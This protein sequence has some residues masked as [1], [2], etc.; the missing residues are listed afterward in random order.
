MDNKK[1]ILLSIGFAI[2]AV[3]VTKMYIN[4]R[5]DEYKIKK[6]VKVVVARAR[7]P[8]GTPIGKKSVKA[9]SIPAQ[10]KPKAAVL[11]KDLDIFL[12]Q[13]TNSDIPSGDYVLENTFGARQTVA[14]R[15]SGLVKGDGN[16]RAVNLPVD[17]TNS[18]ANSVLVG[19]RIDIIYSF[20]IPGVPQKVTSF[21]LQN[22]PIIS[23][24]SYSVA[25]QEVGARGGKS[26]RYNS[27]TLLLGAKDAANLVYARES[28]KINILL[29]NEADQEF[30]DVPP[31]ASVA[32]ILPPGEK[33]KVETLIKQQTQT[34]GVDKEEMRKQLRELFENRSKQQRRG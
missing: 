3:V 16:M 28:G 13:E 6:L 10:Y 12:G 34:H 32:D 24:G 33:A 4:S 25:E 9:K 18:L 17:Q 29:R 8:A 27:F 31:I 7:I 23:T 19:D 11:W 22:V 14:N 21:L 5:V 15:L 20:T 30:V 1:K 26:R 2:I